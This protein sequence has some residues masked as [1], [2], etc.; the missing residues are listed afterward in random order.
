MVLEQ[1]PNREQIGARCSQI[2]PK[3][4]LPGYRRERILTKG[5][6][7]MF[8]LGLKL[9]EARSKAKSTGPRRPLL[10]CDRRP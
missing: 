4:C 2:A 6:W 1:Q 9:G 7:P 3:L 10:M 8:T 5:T